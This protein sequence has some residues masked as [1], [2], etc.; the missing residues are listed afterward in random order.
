[1]QHT[2]PLITALPLPC[3]CCCCCADLHYNQ[4]PTGSIKFPGKTHSG[5]TTLANMLW[6]QGIREALNSQVVKASVTSVTVVGHSMGASVATLVSY[7]AQV[8]GGCSYSLTV[9][10]ATHH[11]CVLL[12]VAMDC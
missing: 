7:A 1:V 2:S 6:Q 11:P 9:L 4:N 5:F 3:C 12:N 10:G 8:G